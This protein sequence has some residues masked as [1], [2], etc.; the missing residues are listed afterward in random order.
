[1]FVSLDNPK[2]K[3]NKT[4]WLNFVH[5]KASITQSSKELQKQNASLKSAKRFKNSLKCLCF[6][7]L[8]LYEMF[9]KRFQQKSKQIQFPIFSRNNSKLVKQTNE[10]QKIS[11]CQ[12]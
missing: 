4:K 12:K 9:T 8:V 6:R 5:L 11:Q 2:S 7:L 3:S 10:K 1:M